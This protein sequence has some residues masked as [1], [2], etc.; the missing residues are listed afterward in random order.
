ML[1]ETVKRECES[2]KKAP[3]KIPY[4]SLIYSKNR[5]FSRI[6]GAKI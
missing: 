1:K 5:P 2:T 6:L 4:L 3:S